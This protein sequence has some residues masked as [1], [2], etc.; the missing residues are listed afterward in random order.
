MVEL[1]ASES[2][3]ELPVAASS[4]ESVLQASSE[5]ELP[6]ALLASDPAE[7]PS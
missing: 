4:S 5:S 7:L 6:V 1:S 2:E 3:S